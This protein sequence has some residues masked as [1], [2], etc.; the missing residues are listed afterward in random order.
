MVVSGGGFASGAVISGPGG[1]QIVS[2]NAVASA[3]TLESR[4][5]QTVDGEADYTVVSNSG[6]QDVT[7]AASPG[8]PWSAPAAPSQ[9]V[10]AASPAARRSPTA[11]CTRRMADW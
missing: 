8:S 1:Y 7:A 4:G 5:N 6:E 2:A 10:A 3:T 11:N 9:W